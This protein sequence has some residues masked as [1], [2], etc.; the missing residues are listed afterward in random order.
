MII[1]AIIVTYNAM[2]RGW[3]D[4]CLQSLQTSTIPVTAIVVD[5]LSTDGTREY[6]PSHYPDA[7]WFPQNKNI[8]FGQAN[9]IGI[10]YA[11][12]QEADYVLLLNQDAVILPDTLALLITESNGIAMIT[13]IHC[14]GDGS[15]FDC[16]F[17]RYTL[18]RV[19]NLPKTLEECKTMKGHYEIGEVCAACWLMP[20]YL[21]KTVGGFNPLFFQYSEDNN[22]FHRMMYHQIKTYLV[23]S[24]QMFHDRMTYG[25]K[26]IYSKQL[27]RRRLLLVLC[28]INNSPSHLVA[29]IFDLLIIC[30][31]TWLPQKA[32]IPGSFAYEL[33]RLLKIAP[34]I[35]SSRKNEQHRGMTW[36]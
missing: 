27:L 28:N 24:A 16:N 14:N 26:K 30:Y 33:L 2:R 29:G 6:V 20:S 19:N 5:N 23:P 13:P 22:Y 12:E 36:L 15:R 8:G 1:Y 7:I 9:N 3:I 10:K 35:Y 21:I 31:T 4:R 17:E 25:N 34:K 11:M 18:A 32:Y